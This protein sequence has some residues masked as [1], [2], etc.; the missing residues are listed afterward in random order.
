VE[1]QQ[2]NYVLLLLLLTNTNQTNPSTHFH[3]IPIINHR[4]L[5]VPVLI[6][7]NTFLS[8]FL[9]ISS[10]IPN[11]A[12][13]LHHFHLL[14]HVGESSLPLTAEPHHHQPFSNDDDEETEGHHLPKNIFNDN[15]NIPSLFFM[16]Q[17]RG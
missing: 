10:R 13:T 16:A 5:A 4:T 1:S 12:N 14:F 17:V 11:I 15:S 3:L 7:V 2:P 9:R 8:F 6:P